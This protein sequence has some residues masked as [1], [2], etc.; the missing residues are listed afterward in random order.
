M[1]VNLFSTG[2]VYQPGVS[3]LVVEKAIQDEV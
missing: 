2:F 3:T 1:A